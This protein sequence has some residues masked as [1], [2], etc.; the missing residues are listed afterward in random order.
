MGNLCNK[1]SF[2]FEISLTGLNRPNSAED[3]DVDDVV[4]DDVAKL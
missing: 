3:D 4:D 2:S 1:G